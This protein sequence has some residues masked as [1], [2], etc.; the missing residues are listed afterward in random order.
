MA[1]V[2]VERGKRHNLKMG[3]IYTGEIRLLSDPTHGPTFAH[4]KLIEVLQRLIV[5]RRVNK[6]PSVLEPWLVRDG[7]LWEVVLPI[8]KGHQLAKGLQS[9]MNR[10]AT[11]KYIASHSA[12]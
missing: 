9:Y 4:Q 6:E 11:F 2:V 1:G 10:R 8:L 12:C 3:N 7:A 5:A